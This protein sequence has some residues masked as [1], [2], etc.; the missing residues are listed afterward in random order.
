M[1]CN[2]IDLIIGVVKNVAVNLKLNKIKNFSFKLETYFQNCL[3][4]VF[5]LY[6]MDFKS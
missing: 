5:N 2:S 1:I 3:Y 6:W 4:R